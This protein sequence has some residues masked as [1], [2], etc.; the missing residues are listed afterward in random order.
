MRVSYPKFRTP[1]GTYVSLKRGIWNPA[2]GTY[3]DSRLTFLNLPVL[4]CHGAVYGVTAS[5]KHHMG[6]MTTSLG[7]GAHSGVRYGGLGAF[8]AQVRMPDLNILDCIYILARP[9]AGPWCT[10]EEATRVNRLVAGVDPV[11][12][13]LWAT[14]HI[15]V[16]AILANGYSSYPMQDPDVPTSIFRT[17]LDATTE[18][19]LDAGKVVTNDLARIEAR[20]CSALGVDAAPPP[21]IRPR[22]F[23]NP[24]GA[25]TTITFEA[26]DASPVQVVIR[27]VA[28]RLVRRLQGA[29]EPERARRV[30]WDGRD[31]EGRRCPPGTYFWHARAAGGGISG[32]VTIVR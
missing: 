19:L 23:P 22:A 26:P 32:K 24:S 12:L 14:K 6:S 18:I 3:D 16:P 5:A 8:L 30:F 17:Y 20:S 11:A 4:K 2:A 28:G 15:L 9:N 7:T 10:Y 29:S 13:D 31:D 1:A 21:G 27:D 25:G